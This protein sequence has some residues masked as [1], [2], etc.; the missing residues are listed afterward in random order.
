MDKSNPFDTSFIPQ[1]PA[2]KIAPSFKPIVEF[3]VAMAISLVLLVAV[4]SASGGM[5]YWKKTVE[6]RLMEKKRQLAGMTEKID[7]DA[8]R[9]LQRVDARL[10]IGKRLLENH[11]AFSAFL[12]LL[13]SDTL[14]SVGITKVEY[15]LKD[16][17]PKVAIIG[18]APGYM[19]LY[20]QEKNLQKVPSIKK[21]SLEKFSVQPASGAV[22]F[23]M[24][25]ELTSNALRYTEILKKRVER[26]TL[27][28]SGTISVATTTSP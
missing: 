20:L 5:Y 23:Q 17:V 11:Y 2:V 7:I 6:T 26:E 22:E 15:E 24:N 9:E 12:D 28:A 25:A 27:S 4:V 10:S 21:L 18:V 19:Q 8:I 3:N 1:Q 16:R 13:E 14:S